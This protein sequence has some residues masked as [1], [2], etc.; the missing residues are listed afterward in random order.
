MTT[1]PDKVLA[2]ILKYGLFIAPLLALVVTRSLFFPFITGKNF[3]FRI[4]VEVLAVL[5]VWLILSDKSY[6]PKK[7]IV[8]W[9][10]GAVM[11]VL[12]LSTVFGIWSYK[13]FWSNFERMEGLWSQLHYFVYFLM[14]G[15]VLRRQ[16]DWLQFFAVT[17]ATSVVMSFY[18]LLQLLGRFEIHQG[19]VRLDG[20]LGNATYLAIYLIFHIFLFGYLF[21]KT[22]NR[23][24]RILFV[25]AAVFELFIVY[26]TATRGAMLGIVAGLFVFGLINAIWASGRTRKFAVIAIIIA[27]LIPIGFLLIKNTSFVQESDVLNRFAS[28]SLEETTTQSRFIIWGM[29]LDAWKE[30]PILGW[31]LESFTYLFS[32]EYKAELWKQEPWFDRAHNVFLDWLTSSGIV[33]L[34]AYLSIFLAA[35]IILKNLFRKGKVNIATVGIFTGLFAAYFVHNLFVFDNFT[36]YLLF[37][38]VLAYIHWLYTSN[39]PESET[40]KT[41][42]EKSFSFSPIAKY[43]LS[44]VTLVAIVFSLYAYNVKPIL[45]AKSIIDTLR[46]ITYSRTDSRVRDLEMGQE[47]LERAIAYDT[48]GTTEIR[49]QLSQYADRI[50]VDP[51]TPDEDKLKIFEF[52]LSEMEKQAE[53]FPYDVRA[54]IFLATLYSKTGQDSKALSA[55]NE[56]IKISPERQQFYF[57]LGEIYFRAGEED[58][59]LKTMEKAYNLDPK[60]PE[61]VHNYA[62]IAIFNGETEFAKNLLQKHFGKTVFA[63][64]RY[65]N[66]YG[67]VSDFNQLILVWRALIEQE[68]S[69]FEYHLGA[70]SIYLK[71]YQDTNAI[72]ELE[73]AAELNPAIKTQV[74]AIIGQIRTGSVPR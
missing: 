63:D 16:R 53:R 9:S 30:R 59:A 35:I 24:L 71:L 64:R 6:R 61:A 2:S 65:I 28:I 19:G 50:G 27:V 25:A 62:I 47:I 72:S 11:L 4:L 34:L 51:D 21:F 74:D 70:A 45:A 52:A 54:K 7:S 56:A 39:E 40:E 10:I 38:S 43:T 48:F 8:L 42:K 73:I 67:A 31:G 44:V 36:S 58:L 33:G 12:V 57:L 41:E 66:A 22:K 3:A 15:S 55:I 5:W 46:V 23:W 68:P 1:K 29:A 18:G 26:H 13:A 32:K 17:L 60:N 69:N 14:L 37:F 49:E 20:T